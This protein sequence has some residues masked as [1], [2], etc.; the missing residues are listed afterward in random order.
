MNERSE[1]AGCA[2]SADDSRGL[3]GEQLGA[4]RVVAA[5]SPPLPSLPAGLRER[6]LARVRNERFAFILAREGLWLPSPDAP[7][8]TKELYHD[9]QDRMTT[10]LI[11]LAAGSSLPPSQLAGRRSLL[12][13]SGDLSSGSLALAA[14]DFMESTD[15]ARQWNA[16]RGALVLEVEERSQTSSSDVVTR[17]SEGIWVASF[18]DGEA[19]VLAR[20]EGRTTCLLRMD[21]DSILPEHEHHGL[22]ELYILRGSCEVEGRRVE[23][24]D[25]HR[26]ADQSVHHPTRACEDGCLGFVSVRNPS[27]LAA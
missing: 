13:V 8:A 22:E 10:R 9:S 25:Y 3:A 14:G 4:P 1:D 18:P 27:R 7:V 17:D 23:T 19:R 11:R 20:G 2:D 15:P 12:I 16:A 5:T 21:P 26:A 24:G 6:I